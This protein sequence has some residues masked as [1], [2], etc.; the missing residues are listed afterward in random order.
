[1]K[2]NVEYF[3]TKKIM[4]NISTVAMVQILHLQ[5]ILKDTARTAT[6]CVCIYSKIGI[7]RIMLCS[8]VSGT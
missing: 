5:N 1:M 8:H 7:L 3:L 4:N 6:S 2:Q